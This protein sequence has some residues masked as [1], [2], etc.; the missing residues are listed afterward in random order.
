V[1]SISPKDGTSLELETPTG[2][3]VLNVWATY[4]NVEWQANDTQA[5]SI[6]NEQ[7]AKANITQ[8][9]TG[10]DATKSG[11]GGKKNEGVNIARN[12]L[13]MVVGSSLVAALF[14]TGLF[15]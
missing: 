5:A 2:T 1:S 15:L 4:I 13:E 9:A 10:G 8:T 12:R 6:M 7:I 11:G 14:M 3:Q